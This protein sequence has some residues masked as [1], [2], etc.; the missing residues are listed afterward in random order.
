[1]TRV[2]DARVRLPQELRPSTTETARSEYVERYDAVLHTNETRARTLADLR[3]EMA[4]AKVDHAIVHAEYE[5]GDPADM[6][7]EAVAA[8][9]AQDPEHFSGYGTISM[10]HFQPMRAV[11]QVARI[12]ELGLAGVNF[13]PSFFGV[14]IDDRR[15]YPVY[16]KATELGLAVGVHT[17]INYSVVHPIKNDHPL[18]LDQVACD[19]PELTLIACHAGWPWVTEMVAVARKHPN[20][21]MDF[22][23]LAPKYLGMP[24]SGWEVMRHFMNSLLAEQILFATDWPVFPIDR[25][26]SEWQALELKPKVLTAL[27]GGNAERL[28]KDKGKEPTHAQ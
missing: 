2:I 16:A 27:L 14:P 3:R 8:L 12:A 11:R 7:N 4:E 15:Y 1:M 10:E 17:G 23:G 26:L 21:L 20:I 6:M 22:G 25:A 18:M 24:G 5:Y 9:V 28:L 13:Q 19:F